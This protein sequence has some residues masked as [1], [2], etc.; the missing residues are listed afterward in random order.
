MTAPLPLSLPRS[1]LRYPGGKSRA[2]RAIAEYIP[3]TESRLCS[4]FLGGGSVELALSSRMDVSAFDS[5]GPLVSFWKELLENPS[6]L[7]YKASLHLPLCKEDFYHL[8]KRIL[9]TRDRLSRAAIFFVLNRSSFSGV[10]LSGGMS[11]GHPRFTLSAIRRVE[12]FQRPRRSFTVKCRDFRDVIPAHPNHFLYLDP[13]YWIKSDNLYGVRGS[14]HKGFDHRGL[15][16]LLSKRDRW[17]L[18]YNDSPQIR[19]LYRGYRIEP[20]S[21]VYGMG[22][23]KRSREIL[24]LSKE[25]R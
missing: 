24:I 13:P 1:P 2:A 3:Q 7:A 16:E 4:P 23:D 5:F 10:T 22:N 18:S 8:Q 17:V 25:A 12:Q 9:K 21:W 11:P 15:F 14:N 20:L 6:R 19:D